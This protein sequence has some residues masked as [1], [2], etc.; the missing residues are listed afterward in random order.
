MIPVYTGAQVLAPRLHTVPSEHAHPLLSPGFTDA[1][2]GLDLPALPRPPTPRVLVLCWGRR[3]FYQHPLGVPSGGGGHRQR[4]EEQSSHRRRPHL[5]I[6]KEFIM[7]L[8]EVHRYSYCLWEAHGGQ[9][10]WAMNCNK[11]SLWPRPPLL[12]TIV[13]GFQWPGYMG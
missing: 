9:Q 8:Q 13:Q 10:P 3:L 7:R 1:G 11:T 6:C 2:Q 12:R 5:E 4:E